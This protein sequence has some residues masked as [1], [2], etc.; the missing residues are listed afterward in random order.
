MGGKVLQIQHLGAG[1]SQCAENA[2]LAAPGGPVDHPPVETRR[3]LL[4]LADDPSAVPAVAARERLRFPAHLAQDM[5]HGRRALAAA[6]AINERP[7]AAV[8]S[9]EECLDVPGN[10]LR[11]Q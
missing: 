1:A 11:H 4:Q 9:S 6:P 10:V 3:K 7:P 2:A 8:L 5:R